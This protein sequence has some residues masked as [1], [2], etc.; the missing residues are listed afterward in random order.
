MTPG[1][2]SPPLG[3][4][5]A[6]SPFCVND[7]P[8]CCQSRYNRAQG[9]Q[10]LIYVEPLLNLYNNPDSFVRIKRRDKKQKQNADHH[11][12]EIFGTITELS[13]TKPVTKLSIRFGEVER[14]VVINAQGTELLNISEVQEYLFPKAEFNHIIKAIE[15]MV[16]QHTKFNLLLMNTEILIEPDS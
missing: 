7:D 12:G 4:F 16:T 13:A 11:L 9:D 3:N 6:C 2:W 5:K 10:F 8:C 1:R 14:Q 15:C